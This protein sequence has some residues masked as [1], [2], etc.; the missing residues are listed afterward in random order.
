MV[1]EKCGPM[2]SG[3]LKLLELPE[4]VPGQ[5]LIRANACG[6]CHTDLHIIEAEWSKACLPTTM[7]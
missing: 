3:P 6:I 2:E 7:D 5:V 4:P 1:L